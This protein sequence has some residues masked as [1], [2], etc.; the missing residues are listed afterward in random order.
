M[1]ITGKPQIKGLRKKG[2]RGLTR[3]PRKPWNAKT[4]PGF[5]GVALVRG[6]RRSAWDKT[7]QL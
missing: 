6:Q 7:C 3:Q 2:D 1:K 5:E 4:E